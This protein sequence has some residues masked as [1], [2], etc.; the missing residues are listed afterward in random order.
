M[1]TRP[2]AGLVG[3]LIIFLL[4]RD[5]YQRSIS[6]KL[7]A[8][9][10]LMFSI[11]ILL[12]LIFL[13]WFNYIRFGDPF[14]NPYSIADIGTANKAIRTLGVFSIQHIPSSLYYYILKSVEPVTSKTLHLEFP[15]VIYSEFGLS[16]FIIAPF[17]F[18]FL[19]LSTNQVC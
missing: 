15:F 12:S 1:L 14:F 17:F 18:M 3:L 8:H 9:K 10:A 2:T 6:G 19:K 13:H 7:F 5:Y 4:L 16:F 11:P